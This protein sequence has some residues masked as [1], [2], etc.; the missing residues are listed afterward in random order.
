MRAIAAILCFGLAA[1]G[2]AD[3]LS[4]EE[5]NSLLDAA[6]DPRAASLVMVCTGCHAEGNERLVGL[7]G[8]TNKEISA[9]LTEYR[10]FETGQTAMHRIARAYSDEDIKLI[11]DYLFADALESEE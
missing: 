7:Q 9:K 10:D 11:S 4:D 5:I 1:C 6:N 8:L 2:G 3:T